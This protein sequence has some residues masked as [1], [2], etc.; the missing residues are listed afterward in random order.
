MDMPTNAA[1]DTTPAAY[2]ADIR[3]RAALWLRTH[4]RAAIAGAAAVAVLALIVAL[5]LLA[6]DMPRGPS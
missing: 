6:K 2:V 3:T 5:I 1:A 4:R